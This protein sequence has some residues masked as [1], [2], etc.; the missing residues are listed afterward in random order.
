MENASRQPLCDMLGCGEGRG[1]MKTNAA[2]PAH[3]RPN[4]SDSHFV[5][6]SSALTREASRNG[7]GLTRKLLSLSAFGQTGYGDIS[8]ENG[9]VRKRGEPGL[10]RAT[11]AVATSWDIVSSPNRENGT[12]FDVGEA[13]ESRQRSNLRL[14]S[15]QL[16]SDGWWARKQWQLVGAID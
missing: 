5:L 7:P 4:E 11:F 14:Q 13:G 2:L 3:P 1:P 12:F 6:A 15:A 8:R 9:R 10:V 16:P